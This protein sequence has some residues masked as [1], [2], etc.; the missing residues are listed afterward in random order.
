L[1]KSLFFVPPE[2]WREG[3]VQTPYRDFLLLLFFFFEAMG[4]FQ[5]LL[6]VGLSLA[7][8]VGLNNTSTESPLFSLTEA[9]PSLLR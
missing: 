5:F 1:S 2:T 4:L 9:R 7:K 8:K 3:N 6:P